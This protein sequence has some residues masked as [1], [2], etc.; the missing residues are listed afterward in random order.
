M[1]E[2][3]TLICEDCKNEFIFTA[4]EQETVTEYRS[5]IND[6]VAEMVAQFVTGTTDIDAGWDAYLS[7]LE[8]MGLSQYLSAVQS[9]WD[10]MQG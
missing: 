2:N 5:T 6:Y 7:E 1:Y 4:E 10:R 9:C 3:K 8:K